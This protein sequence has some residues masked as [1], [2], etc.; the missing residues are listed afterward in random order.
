MP[1]RKQLTEEELE[2]IRNLRGQMSAKDIQKKYGIGAPRLY[3]IWRESASPTI[4]KDTVG[5]K[6][7]RMDIS[8]QNTDRVESNRQDIPVQTQLLFRIQNT[9]QNIDTTLQNIDSRII[10]TQEEVESVASDVED[11]DD[12]VEDMEADASTTADLSKK[13]YE[14]TKMVE[15]MIYYGAA[16]LSIL[17]VLATT[18]KFIKRTKDKDSFEEEPTVKEPKQKPAANTNTGEYF[19]LP[20]QKPKDLFAME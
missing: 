5:T 19:D 6:P 9:L 18:W 4:Q 10:E 15:K 1:P 16:A 20:I 12:K 8:L 3:K 17:S 7:N 11:I 13:I 2:E 14:A